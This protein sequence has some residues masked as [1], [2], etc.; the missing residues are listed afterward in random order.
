MHPY[1]AFE[2]WFDAHLKAGEAVVFLQALVHHVQQPGVGGEGPPQPLK[3]V[4]EWMSDSK[5][6]LVD[7][8]YPPV[9]P[10]S[11]Q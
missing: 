7:A 4:I 11:F 1:M 6:P 3:P 5:V 10:G 2:K 8:G 9:N